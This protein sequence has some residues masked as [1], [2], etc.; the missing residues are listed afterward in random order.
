MIVMFGLSF[1]AQAPLMLVGA[2][3]AMLTLRADLTLILLVII[4]LV[5][6]LTYVVTVRSRALYALVQS[7][8]DR[9]NT[10]L[11]ENLVGARVVRAFVRGEQE[12]ER[13]EDVNDDLTSTAIRV[14]QLVALLLPTLLIIMNLATAV[15]L[16]LGGNAVIDGGL[17]EGE[18][19]AFINYLGMAAF[20]LIIFAMVQ[21]MI[22]AG[23]ASSTRIVEVLDDVPAV[24]DRTDPVEADARTTAGR[25]T[26]DGVSFAYGDGEDVLCNIDLV[27]EPNT[28]LAILGATGSGKSTLVGLVPRFYDPTAG[29]VS[30][31]GVDV[32]TMSQSA[33]RTS[34][35]ISLQKATLFSGT[36]ADN[37]A[38]GVPGATR[39]EIRQAAVVAQADEFVSKLDEGYD[40]P[41]E[42]GGTN[43]SGGQRQRLAIARAVLGDRPIL[44]LDDSTSAVDVATESQIQAALARTG[45]SRTTLVVA[46]RISTA[47]AADMIVVL[48]DGEICAHGPHEELILTSTQY[49]EIYR[50]Q[51]GEPTE[52]INA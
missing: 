48:E 45:G 23:A 32:A 16:W 9:L 51:L 28:T 25:I 2:L 26:F 3:V 11:R 29:R 15:I 38:Y 8:L 22:A 42:A 19:I 31:D 39:E 47:L 35:G 41:V 24:L 21:P 27:V 4:P 7:R 50:S 1:L 18:L 40:S 46:Q 10:V 20:P 37:I 36:I 33:L 13:F 30:I 49:Q 14:N 43:F 34:I 44:I 52:S 6:A 17:L 12:Q 5:G